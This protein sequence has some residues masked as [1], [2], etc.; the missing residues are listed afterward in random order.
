[1]W[2]K[3]SAINDGVDIFIFYKKQEITILVIIL[4]TYFREIVL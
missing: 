4:I 1:M 2:A 3:G